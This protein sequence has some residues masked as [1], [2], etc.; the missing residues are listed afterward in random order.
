MK[1]RKRNVLSRRFTRVLAV[2]MAAAL[3]GGS[4]PFVSLGAGDGEDTE[5]VPLRDKYSG[6]RDRILT[7]NMEA[8]RIYPVINNIPK[9][10]RAFF[11]EHT[12]RRFLLKASEERTKARWR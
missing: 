8:L 1:D 4:L 11:P 2:L 5:G 9:N 10:M 6:S 3:L 12:N 7:G